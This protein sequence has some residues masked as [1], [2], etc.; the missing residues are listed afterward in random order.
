MTPLDRAKDILTHCVAGRTHQIARIV[1][2]R[3]DSALEAHGLT[4]HQLT[5]LSMICMMQPVAPASMLPYLKMDQ[6]T[7]SRNLDRLVNKGWLEAVADDN[8]RRFSPSQVDGC[9]IWGA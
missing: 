3:Y 8:D 7:L 9:G 1:S 5:L 6:S 4:S 2:A